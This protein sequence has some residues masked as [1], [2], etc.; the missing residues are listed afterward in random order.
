MSADEERLEEILAAARIV[1]AELEIVLGAEAEQAALELAHLIDAVETGQADGVELFLFL[2]KHPV[3]RHLMLALFPQLPTIKSFLTGARKKTRCTGET[4]GGVLG[5]F[6]P[7][8]GNRQIADAEKYT[9]PESGCTYFRYLRDAGQDIPQCPLHNVPLSPLGLL[10]VWFAYRWSL[11]A[12]GIYADLLE[13]TFDL[14]RFDLYRALQ[15]PLPTGQIEEKSLVAQLNIY[16]ARGY[17][18]PGFKYVLREDS[19]VFPNDSI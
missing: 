18:P 11:E 14:H 5:H 8:A 15:W 12:A 13:A 9:C 4:R 7:L 16:L 17:V 6:S 1:Q 2:V 19:K 10:S 3:S